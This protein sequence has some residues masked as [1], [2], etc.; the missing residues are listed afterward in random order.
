MQFRLDGINS[1]VPLNGTNFDNGPTTIF[2]ADNLG[3]GD[4]Q[5]FVYIIS[6]EQN[7]TVAVDYFEY[8]IALLQSVTRVIF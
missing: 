3:D 7:G 2:S 6:L 1:N 4:H 8:A 5:L